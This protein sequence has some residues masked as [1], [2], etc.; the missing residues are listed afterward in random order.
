[1][2]ENNIQPEIEKT[3]NRSTPRKPHKLKKKIGLVILAVVL[4]LI[5]AFIGIAAYTV[6]FHEPD[7]GANEPPPFDTSALISPIAP[8]TNKDANGSE[9]P[10]VPGETQ[11]SAETQEL[12]SEQKIFNFLFV[13]QDRI[14]LN[15]DVIMLI[16]F[17]TTKN[18]VNVLQIPRDTYIEISTYSGKI[19]GLYAHYY[20]SNGYNIKDG[21]RKFANTLEQSLCIK[22][23]NI[24]HINLDGVVAI[25]DA[26]GGVDVNVPAAIT[27]YDQTL[28]QNVTIPAGKQ[29][30]NGTQAERF[31]RHRSSYLQADIG[32][33]DAQK[34]FVSAF[35][36]K[37]KSSFNASTVSKFVDI[38]FKNVT[39]DVSLADAVFY[40]KQLLKVDMN[41]IN[42]M[43][44]VGR[45]AMSNPDG[46]GLSFWIMVRKNIC[47]MINTYF[48]I[49]DFEITD[50]I[51]DP[52]RIFTSTI[53]YPHINYIYTRQDIST[54]DPHSAGD[55]NDS[56]IHIPHF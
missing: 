4:T 48:N 54:D 2:E 27:Y 1:M 31:V 40:A 25:V 22:I 42:L 19:N 53:R 36:Q 43:S 38:A 37:L 44:M 24:G 26:I 49:Y 33:I 34:A 13:G 50:A 20:L 41:E 56:S 47:E 17:N 9:E 39:T 15:T 6:L 12:R 29:H 28:K 10:T 16:S 45:G 18:T 46:T 3:D 14:A 32:R 55:I 30:L 51:F 52:N 5:L 8:E 23:H 7:T 21:L 11:P 35:I